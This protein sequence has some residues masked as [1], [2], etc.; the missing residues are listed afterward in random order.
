MADVSRDTLRRPDLR[1]TQSDSIPPRAGRIAVSAG[2]GPDMIY[3]V[4]KARDVISC[5]RRRD[6]VIAN[7]TDKVAGDC[8]NGST[9]ND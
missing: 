1:A 6:L 5:G 3:A 7:R 4:D 9:G 2:A 8:R